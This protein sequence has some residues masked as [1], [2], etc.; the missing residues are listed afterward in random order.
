MA[1]KR[2]FSL[3]IVD[4]D[5]FL[6]MPTS[7]QALYFHLA[8]RADDD[9]FVS[10][11]KKIA[12]MSS[13]SIDD[14]KVL[15]SKGYVIQFKSG[16]CVITDWKIHNYIPK[17]RYRPTIYT[18]EKE[19]LTT[20][21]N[22]A[23][24]ATDTDCIQNDDKLYTDCIRRLDKIRLDKIS[25]DKNNILLGATNAD[26][27]HEL[28]PIL[29]LM[30]NDKS[31]YKVYQSQIDHWHELYPAV[32]IKQELL[33]MQGWLES[34]PKK[35]KTKRGITAFITNWLSKSQDKG[36]NIKNPLQNSEPEYKSSWD[37]T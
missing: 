14:L 37:N 13:C 24:T 32:D 20:A 30:L 35:R 7:S 21:E 3:D 8:M 6:E 33:K 10:S 16:V 31:F 36:G 1:R 29:K 2:M 18:A 15:I 5:I 27:E 26:T 9:G 11:P 4:S 28:T 23:Y 12:N 22:K 19:L 25:I 34:N 17:D